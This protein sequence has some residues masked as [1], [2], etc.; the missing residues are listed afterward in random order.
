M[1]STAVSA[2]SKSVTID[3]AKHLAQEPH[4]G[5]NR[6]HPDL[7]PVLEVD[8]GEAVAFET[9]DSLD[10]YLN[11]TSSVAGFPALQSGAVHPLAGPV[12]VHGA[13]PGDLLGVGFLARA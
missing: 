2:A 13:S 5:H 11:A 6:W 8:A 3:R 4:T 12:F 10:G 9:R 1:T 7:V